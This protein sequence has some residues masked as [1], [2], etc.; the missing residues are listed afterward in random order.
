MAKSRHRPLRA[1]ALTA[2]NPQ[3]L[4]N[5]GGIHDGECSP[6]LCGNEAA[7]MP[8]GSSRFKCICPHDSSPPTHD[9]RCPNRLTVPLTPRPIH[10]IIPPL[11]LNSTSN[12]TLTNGLSN[13]VEAGVLLASV[14]ASCFLLAVFT[15][16]CCWKGR[17]LSQCCAM[18]N[19]CSKQQQS[20]MPLNLSKGLLASEHYTPNPQYTPCSLGDVSPNLSVPTLPRDSLTFYQEI[21]EG[22]F[23]KVYKGEWRSEGLV[24]TVAIKVLKESATREAEEDFMREVEIMSAFKHPNILTLIGVALREPNKSP[25]M[26]FEFMAHGDLT[27]VLRSNGRLFRPSDNNKL[28]RLN[29]DSLLN[30]ATQIAQGMAYLAAQRFVHRDLACRN[31]LVGDNL[32][33]KIAD[34]GMSRD[35]Y[36]CDYYKIGGSRL[37]PVR[38]ISPESVIYG[39][40]TLES[41]VWSYGVVLWEIYSFGKQPY[42]GHSNEEV[43][44]LILQGIMLIPP[45]DCPPYI[46]ELMRCCW[47]TEPR[48][49]TNFA[50]ILQVLHR[51]AQTPQSSVQ[52]SLPRPPAFPVTPQTAIEVLDAENYLKPLQTEPKEYLQTLPD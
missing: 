48:D 30:I 43:V 31:C 40:F 22:C 45:E 10:N 32:R 52:L 18:S 7:C 17:Q 1:E 15:A 35:V 11:G 8:V 5:P 16:V 26:V 42:F 14:A 19:K 41:D 13:T 2:Q 12:T 33:V 51:A 37:L 49:R 46:C 34:F 50:E 28:P 27:E 3:V 36:T 4:Q 39:R 24:E 9:L 44:R 21:G 47:K 25:W 20:A 38:W 23:G 29:K 6:G